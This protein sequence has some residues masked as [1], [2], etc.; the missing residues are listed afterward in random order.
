MN[1]TIEFHGLPL[2][3][4]GKKIISLT[5]PDSSTYRDI[6]RRLATD[7]PALVDLIIDRDRET[8]L[9]SNMF[10]INGDLATLAMRMDE[11]PPNGVH[12]I[13]MSVITGG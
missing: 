3:V 1:L 6:I 4:V 7:Y 10:V 13:L 5:L 11:V 8:F 2:A 12:L 9:S